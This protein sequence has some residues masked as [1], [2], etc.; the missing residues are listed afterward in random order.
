MVS[1]RSFYIIIEHHGDH[2]VFD[3]L[4]EEVFASTCLHHIVILTA[5]QDIK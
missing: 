4:K 2:A 3:Y 1:L 5:N